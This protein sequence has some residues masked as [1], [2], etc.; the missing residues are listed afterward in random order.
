MSPALGNSAHPVYRPTSMSTSII[1]VPRPF[2]CPTAP[3]PQ[4]SLAEHMEITGIPRFLS[5]RCG[6]RLDFVRTSGRYCLRLSSV[7]HHVLCTREIS[8]SIRFDSV[9]PKGDI[10]VKDINR[11]LQ[12]T[13]SIFLFPLLKAQTTGHGGPRRNSPGS[14]TADGGRV[15][16]VS[17]IE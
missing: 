11:A 4:S 9:V 3:D 15:P 17:L 16:R 5:L 1:D 14:S 2:S 8:V 12:T 7:C 13:L 10:F 6:L